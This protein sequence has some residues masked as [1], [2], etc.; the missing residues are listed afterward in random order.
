[1]AGRD[2][3]NMAEKARTENTRRRIEHSKAN[4]H[5]IM[6]LQIIRNSK[7]E[8]WAEDVAG[9][10]DQSRHGAGSV[11]SS[12]RLLHVCC[13]KKASRGRFACHTMS[14]VFIRRHIRAKGQPAPAAGRSA[15][16]GIG[17]RNWET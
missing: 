17:W 5:Q 8:V 1:M 10:D 11:A 7:T 12:G 6:Q 13:P 15:C 3:A 9:G 14:I 4:D 2:T 16:R